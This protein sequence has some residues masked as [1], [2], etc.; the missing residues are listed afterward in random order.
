MS[1]KGKVGY[2]SRKE[3]NKAIHPRKM[4]SFKRKVTEASV[5]E[6]IFDDD[7]KETSESEE[8]VH[9]EQLPSSDEDFGMPSTSKKQKTASAIRFATTAKLSTRKAHK[10][11]KT[12]SESGVSILTPS[13]SG[14]YRA[15]M[16]KGEELKKH[17]VENLKHENWCL[18]FDGKTIQKKEYQVVVLKN[19]NKDIRLA[20]VELANGKGKTIFDG[21]KVILDE[22]NPWS[23]IKMIVSD[24]TAANTGKSLGAVTLLQNHFEHNGQEKPVFIGCQHHILDT[25]LKHVLND[26]LGGTPTSPNLSYP[27]IARLTEEYAQLKQAFNNTGKLLKKTKCDRWRDDMA[28]LYHLISCYKFFKTS[29]T[30]SK[31]NFQSLPALSSARWNC[32]AIY[33]LLAFI[34]MPEYRQKDETA[35]DFIIGS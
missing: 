10:V 16:R 4:K 19:E 1:T 8:S 22:C 11:C 24:T 27:F 5:T 2:C 20:D 28:F 31:V 30:L 26:H 14:V 33:T 13:Q 6:E 32:R 15:V 25:I 12:L 9:E 35:C 34:L 18:H 23:S 29:Q 7:T 3:G 21:T 17:F